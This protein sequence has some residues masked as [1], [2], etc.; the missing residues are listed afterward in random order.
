MY[1]YLQGASGVGLAVIQLCK[2]LYL[3]VTV[4]ATAGKDCVGGQNS[5]PVSRL[6]K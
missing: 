4:I 1:L 3:N 6:M 2:A 5:L